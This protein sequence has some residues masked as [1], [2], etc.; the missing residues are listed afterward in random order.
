MANIDITWDIEGVLTPEQ[1]VNAMIA[2]ILAK[3]LAD[4]GTFWTWEG[5][6]HP[7]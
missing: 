3:G 2:V 7:W 5:K 1:S 6:V 4:S